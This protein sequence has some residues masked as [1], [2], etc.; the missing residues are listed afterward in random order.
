MAAYQGIEA[1]ESIASRMD[2]LLLSFLSV[3]ISTDH[4][5][6]RSSFQSLL[7]LSTLHKLLEK[8]TYKK[9]LSIILTLELLELLLRRTILDPMSITSKSGEDGVVADADQ[10][11]LVK[12]RASGG[13]CDISL[14]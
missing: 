14:L 10:I 11:Q 5:C 4:G 9:F 13:P 12:S 6:C 2:F 7:I 3:S 8:I 1:G